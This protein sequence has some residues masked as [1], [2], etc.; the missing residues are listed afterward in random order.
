MNR[1]RRASFVAAIPLLFWLSAAMPAG[2]NDAIN[3]FVDQ[4]KLI[5]IPE[6]IGTLV[7]G[8][9]LI[10]DVSVQAGGTL[11]VT[12]KSYGATNLIALDRQGNVLM[13]KTVQVEGIR[14]RT[15]T[16]YRGVQRE[17]YSCT[18]N[19]ERRITL[20][21]GNDFFAATI[22]QAGAR[23]SQAQSGQAPR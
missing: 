1:P 14:D 6:K 18:P 22:G 12:G 15:V 21:D 11:V 19:C 2:A 17:T 4:A 23:S 13:E 20:G 9:P 16:V 8:N 10:A 3:V 5:K 7:I